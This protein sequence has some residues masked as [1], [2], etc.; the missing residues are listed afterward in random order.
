MDGSVID[1][2]SAFRQRE[3][4]GDAI[5]DQNIGKLKTPVKHTLLFF[6]LKVGPRGFSSSLYNNRSGIPLLAA[7]VKVLG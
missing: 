5:M 3:G 7:Q 1:E 6:T 2:R 4:G